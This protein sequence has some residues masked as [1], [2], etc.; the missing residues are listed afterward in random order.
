[1]S[2]TGAEELRRL[3]WQCRR[4]VLE[5][6]L[7]FTRFLASGFNRLSETER[8]VF[9]RLLH[10]SDPLLL[11][12]VQGHQMPPDELKNIIEKVTTTN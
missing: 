1:V 12:W 6:D 3:R 2:V 10:E 11:S 5:L 7:L 8:A 9:T 4:G